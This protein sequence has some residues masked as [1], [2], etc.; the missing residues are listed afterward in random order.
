MARARVTR[1]FSAGGVVFRLTPHSVPSPASGAPALPLPGHDLLARVEIA[2][3]GR[4][5]SDM[6]FLPKGTPRRAEP[7]ED[8]ALRE[9]REE[10]GLITR[11]VGE[12]GS[13]NYT[14]SRDGTRYRKEV[15]HFLL[16]A[17]GGDVS[18]HDSEYDEARWFPLAE[19]E[20]R[21]AYVNEAELVRRAAPMIRSVLADRGQPPAGP[22]RPAF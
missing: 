22:G 12:L 9:V 5:H 7:V 15:L 2:L 17:V 13:I 16:E 4:T 18:L 6:W 8:T 1:T 11:V 19:A 21:L 20:R 10:T 14:F 3:V